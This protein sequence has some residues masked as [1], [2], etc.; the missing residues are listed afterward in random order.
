MMTPGFAG[1]LVMLTTNAVTR[2][3]LRPGSRWLPLVPLVL[4]FFLGLVSTTDATIARWKRFVF[5]IINSLVIF[6]V[7]TGANTI[8]Q[9]AT[10]TTVSMTLSSKAYAQENTTVGWCCAEGRVTQ[11]S[12]ED[13]ARRLGNFYSTSNEARN[14]CSANPRPTRAPRPDNPFFRNWFR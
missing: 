9:A 12:R 10:Q 14:A 11:A 2:P 7:A 13:C 1:A 4:S 3:F 8:G 6:S 5:Y